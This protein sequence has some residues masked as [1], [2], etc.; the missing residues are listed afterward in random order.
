MQSIFR[1]TRAP[2]QTVYRLICLLPVDVLVTMSTEIHAQNIRQVQNTGMN[3]SCS[4]RLSAKMICQTVIAL[5]AP[6]PSSSLW[7]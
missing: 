4:V 5:S 1:G 2:T 3:E 7:S 6:H